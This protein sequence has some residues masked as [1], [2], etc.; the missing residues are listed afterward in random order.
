MFFRRL[1][2]SYEVQLIMY[3]AKSSGVPKTQCLRICR[4]VFLTYQYGILTYVKLYCLVEKIPGKN[5]EYGKSTELL[6]Q[7]M[8]QDEA[9]VR[10]AEPRLKQS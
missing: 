10:K 6:N 7:L 1:F 2:L 5:T 3:F 8:S 9:S 4:L